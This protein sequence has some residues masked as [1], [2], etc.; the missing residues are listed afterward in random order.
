ML[1]PL[2]HAHTPG[3]EILLPE[4]IAHFEKALERDPGYADAH[5]NLGVMFFRQGRMMSAEQH[6]ETALRLQPD[7][8][9]AQGNLE[10]LRAVGQ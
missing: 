9:D 1:E 3:E 2:D 4:A 5:N 10:R 7:H 6:F 8:T